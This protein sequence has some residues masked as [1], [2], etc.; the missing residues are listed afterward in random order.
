MPLRARKDAAKGT[1]KALPELYELKEV[2]MAT[3]DR[4]EKLERELSRAR[5]RFH[6]LVVWIGVCLASL[7]AAYTY[8]QLSLKPRPGSAEVIEELRARNFVLEDGN[9]RVR[10]ILG[11]YE[12]GVMLRLNAEKGDLGATFYLDNE[13]SGITLNDK[14]GKHR[15]VLAVTQNVPILCLYDDKEEPRASLAVTKDGP[16]LNMRDAKGQLVPIR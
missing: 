14:D 7:A 5:T 3:D 15:A 13:R 9:G 12:G 8:A 2:E 6:L 10:A 4:L 16:H 1:R 11:M